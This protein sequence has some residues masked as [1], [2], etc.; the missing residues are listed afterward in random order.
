MSPRRWN[1]LQDFTSLLREHAESLILVLVLA[2]ILRWT[3]ISS[4]VVRSDSLY[5]TALQGDILL[6]LRLP[7]GVGVSGWGKVIDGRPARRGELVVFDCP[8]A[9][10]LCLKRVVA[11]PGDRIEMIQQRLVLNGQPCEYQQD[12]KGKV[13]EPPWVTETCLGQ[14]RRVGLASSWAPESWGPFVVP[15]GQVYVLSDNRP[16]Q[17]DSR[18][19]GPV[20][21][22]QMKAVAVRVILSLDWSASRSGHLI[23][24]ARTFRPLN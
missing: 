12:E 9:E 18:Q 14:S 19:W 15:P 5:P 13:S 6:G 17:D 3:V 4:Y 20:L 24:W 2:L 23:R 10:G 8:G 16:I 22:A 21:E 11:I 1:A 7:F